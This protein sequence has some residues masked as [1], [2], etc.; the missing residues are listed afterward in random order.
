MA[1][2][3]SNHSKRHN[4]SRRVSLEE[5]TLHVVGHVRQHGQSSMVR[6]MHTIWG[7]MVF[8]GVLVVLMIG[9]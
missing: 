4:H 5:E 6:V 9:D 3:G 8:G 2:D 1:C 7:L